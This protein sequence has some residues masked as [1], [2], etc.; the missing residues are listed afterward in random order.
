MKDYQEVVST[1]EKTNSLF[2]VWVRRKDNQVVLA[3]PPGF[4]NRKFFIA[5]TVASGERYA[6]LQAGDMYVY[7]KRQ[8]D[9]MLLVEPQLATRSTGDPQSKASV[10]RLYTDRVVADL[11]ILTLLTNCPVV[12]LDALFVGEAGK[13]FGMSM[14][15]E[16]KKHLASIKTI[17]SFPSNLEIAFDIPMA[18]GVL[19]T[20]HYSVSEIRSNATFKPRAADERIGY[21]TTSFA[22]LGKYQAEESKVRYINRWHLE[23]ADTSLKVS[24]ARDPIVFYIENTTPIRYRR[25]VREGVLMWNKAFEQ[26]GIANAIEVYFQDAATGAHMEKDP[27]DVRYNFIRWLNNNIG[28]AIGPSRVNPLT[29]EILDADIILTDGWIRHFWRQFN[30]VLPQLAMEGFSPE[31]LDWLKTPPQLGSAR[32]P[33]AAGRPVRDHGAACTGGDA[34]ARRTT[35][36]PLRRP[37]DGTK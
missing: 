4:E 35:L 27:E 6:G 20:L 12:D 31:T 30:E 28:T 21:F 25:W 23:K 16:M 36:E 8:N 3:F 13:F 11:P 29:G 10:S 14:T 32:A 1:M 26:V 24:P 7:W 22:D 5:M 9:R 19:K 15:R 37:D 2:S 34:R 18:D 17:K 33:G